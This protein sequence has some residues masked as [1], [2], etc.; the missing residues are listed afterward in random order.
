MPVTEEKIFEALKQVIDPEL[1]VKPT[2]DLLLAISCGPAG[3][4][5][6]GILMSSETYNE[7][8]RTYV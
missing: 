1:F 5:G 2:T 6:A 3:Q 8:T 7:T 4:A